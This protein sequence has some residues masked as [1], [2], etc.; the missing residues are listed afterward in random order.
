VQRVWRRQLPSHIDNRNRLVA[1]PQ[2][3]FLS[4]VLHL[5]ESNELPYVGVR[6]PL[7]WFNDL[8]AAVGIDPTQY[9][10]LFTSP[11]TLTPYPVV[12]GGEET[13]KSRMLVKPNA[14]A[15]PRTDRAR[16][17]F[18]RYSGRMLVPDRIW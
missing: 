12:H 17:I 8:V 9:H 2:P 7:T 4:S 13:V 1:I 10:E 6:I 14:Y 5:L 16:P 15:H 18:E 3:E 11:R